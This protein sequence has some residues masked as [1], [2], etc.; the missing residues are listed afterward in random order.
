M[1]VITKSR[2]SG[3]TT[4]LLKLAQN[5]QYA[6]VC[7]DLHEYHRIKA[8]QP[9]IPLF[10][11]NELKGQACKGYKIK[12]FVIDNADLCIPNTIWTDNWKDAQTELIELSAKHWKYIS[13]CEHS[14]AY[15]IATKAKELGYNIPFPVLHNE[16]CHVKP[17][18][19]FDPEEYLQKIAGGPIEYVTTSSVNTCYLTLPHL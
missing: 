2:G 5:S 7:C 12:G 17:T 1:K 16:R 10:T 4:E 8:L 19:F 13:V 3:K 15:S 18:L 6:F 14:Q 11:F 9:N